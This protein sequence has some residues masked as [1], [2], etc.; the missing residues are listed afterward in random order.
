MN[1][2]ETHTN[3]DTSSKHNVGFLKI[4]KKYVQEAI[5]PFLGSLHTYKN[6]FKCPK[7]YYFLYK[8]IILKYVEIWTF[9][10]II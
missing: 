5:L 1:E 6:I 2:V 8:G 3:N 10:N 4:V 9:Q 7:G